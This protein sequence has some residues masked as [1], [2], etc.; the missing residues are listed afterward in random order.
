MKTTKDQKKINVNKCVEFSETQ[1]EKDDIN[2]CGPNLYIKNENNVFHLIKDNAKESSVSGEK[3]D[4]SS[5]K[6]EINISPEVGNYMSF[7]GMIGPINETLRGTKEFA[8][9]ETFGEGNGFSKDKTTEKNEGNFALKT[10]LESTLDKGN[11][12]KA[13]NTVR[14]QKEGENI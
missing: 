5:Y 14:E 10:N 12:E 6:N 9:G 8:E 7:E 4:D 2:S 13:E 11:P 3:N 1:K